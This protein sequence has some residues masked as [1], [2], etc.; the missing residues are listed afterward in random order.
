RL[1]ENLLARGF[2]GTRRPPEERRH[3]AGEGADGPFR[4]LGV[5]RTRPRPLLRRLGRSCGT[6]LLAPG[7]GLRRLG[8]GLRLAALAAA[9]GAPRLLPVLAWCARGLGFGAA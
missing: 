7:F 8:L 5:D 2:D 6:L 9:F 1:R 3:V 4:G